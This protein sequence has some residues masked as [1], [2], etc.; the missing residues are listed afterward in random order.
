MPSWSSASAA[1]T[2]YSNIASILPVS[3]GGPRD[4]EHPPLPREQHARNDL[5][6]VVNTAPVG[7]VV[8]DART[9]APVSFN[10]EAER[11]A[12]TLQEPGQRPEELLQV[13]TV[14]RADGRQVSLEEATMARA[15]S[16]G[17]T[18][19]A[20]EIVIRVPDGRAI[21]ILTNVTRSS[22]S[23]CMA[24]TSTSSGPSIWARPTMSSSRSRRRSWRPGSGRPCVSECPPTR[25]S[26]RRRTCWGR[27]STSPSA[28]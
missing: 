26:P 2:V 24:W 25:P 3:P 13:V 22:S 9:G 16:T 7:V 10:P 8:F 20:E 4:R 28:A 12:R 17:E 21:T 1:T 19:R 18:V 11:I 15:L 14:R 5:E 23:R 27:P 6:A